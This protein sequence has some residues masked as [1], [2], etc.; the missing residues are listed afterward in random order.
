MRVPV[1]VD[2][3]IPARGAIAAAGL[4]WLLAGARADAPPPPPPP[5]G[6]HPI[7]WETKLPIERIRMG[8]QAR[9]RFEDAIG[10]D[11][12]KDRSDDNDFVGSRIR[13]DLDIDATDRSGLFLQLQDARSWGGDPLVSSDNTA[14]RLGSGLDLHQGYVRAR[15]GAWSVR[16]GRQALSFGDQKLISPLDWSNVGRAFDGVAVRGEGDLVTADLLA[17]KVGES[18]SADENDVELHGIHTTWRWIEGH[19]IDL[20]AF[21][22]R[23]QRNAGGEIPTR[24]ARNT[25]VYTL[26]ARY[27]SEGIP[28]GIGKADVGAEYD[29]QSGNRG[30]DDLRAEAL[31]AR[32]GCTLSD[33]PWKPR[34]GYHFDSASGDSDPADGKEH[35]FDQLFPLSHEYHGYIDLVGR[36]NIVSHRIQASAKPSDALSVAADWHLFRLESGRD[37]LYGASGAV[38]RAA[39]AGGAPKD[40]G[41]EVD[42]TVRY[43]F[44]PSWSAQAGWSRLF[45]GRL[46]AQTRTASS[47]QSD[48]QLLY[49]QTTLQF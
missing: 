37:A 23:D 4:L 1:P 35:T 30:S 40:V 49:V 45:T 11:H 29:L 16:A 34:L 25:D 32:A 9:L 36:R 7:R 48:A 31:H 14:S 5:A 46:F 18:P 41:E 38:R 6:G 39:S 21:W 17:T 47:G 28:L 15:E 43:R 22:S 33:E 24:S 13:L 20:Y 19:P 26:G 12:L 27:A 44:G 2:A 8:A 42:L 10:H 3:L